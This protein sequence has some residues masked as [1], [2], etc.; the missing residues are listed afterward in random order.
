ED[1]PPPEPQAARVT[2]ADNAVR[3]AR[4]F[5]S[6]IRFLSQSLC[7][8]GQLVAGLLTGWPPRLRGTS[9]CGTTLGIKPRQ[10]PREGR[11]TRN[12]MYAAQ[13]PRKL[14]ASFNRR[15]ERRSERRDCRREDYTAKAA[16]FN[17]MTRGGSRRC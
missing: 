6:F 14:A 1:D 3:P 17:A 16:L 13:G 9:R 11:K 8:P 7:E 10:D 15:G 12:A 4:I 5:R 2:A